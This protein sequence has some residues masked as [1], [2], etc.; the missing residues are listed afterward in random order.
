MKNRAKASEPASLICRAAAGILAMTGSTVA[1]GVG[2]IV[3]GCAVV[4]V[5]AVD[6]T[7]APSW[8]GR[9]RRPSRN[10]ASRPRR[11]RRHTAEVFGVGEPWQRRSSAS[12]VDRRSSCVVSAVASSEGRRAR[13]VPP[14]NLEPSCPSRTPSDAR[15]PQPP[16]F[17]SAGPTGDNGDDSL[18]S[19]AVRRCDSGVSPVT[20]PRVSEH[21][22]LAGNLSA[23]LCAPPRAQ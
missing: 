17:A 14:R 8:P 18:P 21:G 22:R 10:R 23:V 15:R 12:P 9:G 7:G 13:S 6:V 11:A 4:V 1:V 5:A 3:V 20:H 19:G 16:E 2:V